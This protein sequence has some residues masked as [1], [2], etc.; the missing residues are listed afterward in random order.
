[1]NREHLVFRFKS[2]LSNEEFKPVRIDFENGT[3]T[4]LERS[5]YVNMLIEDCEMTYTPLHHAASKLQDIVTE[6][7]VHIESYPPDHPPHSR[8]VMERIKRGL[9][10]TGL[11]DTT[12]NK[13]ITQN[14]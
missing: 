7:E 10:A 3:V 12:P 6:L 2:K 9:E 5:G 14:S 1:M 13:S 4:K 11:V 8:G